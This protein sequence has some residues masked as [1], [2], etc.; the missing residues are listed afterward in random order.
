MF[1]TATLILVNMETNTF[2]CTMIIWIKNILLYSFNESNT[3][4]I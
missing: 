2:G 4:E 3:Y 1:L